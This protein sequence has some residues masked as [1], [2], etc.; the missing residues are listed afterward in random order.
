[1]DIL[2]RIL[3]DQ[4]GRARGQTIV[5]EN[6]PGGGSVIATEA[7]ARAAP[8]GSTVLMV[9]NSF[10]INPSLKATNYDPLTSFDPICH[11]ARTPNVFAV[12]ASSPYRTLA[13][14]LAAARGKP[15][16]LT[17]ASV[18]PATT[19]HI[20]IEMFKRAAKV[21]MT[22]VPFSG[23]APAVNAL[24]G[25]H[26]TALFA[27]HTA[28]GGHLEAGRIRGLAIASR[29]RI[30]SLP[31]LPTVTESGLGDYEVDAWFGLVAPAKVPREVASQLA[32]WFSAAMQAPE[33]KV[34]LAGQRLIPVGTCG[35]EFAAHLRNQYDQYSRVVREANIKAE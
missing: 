33:V 4:I 3:A 14:L 16:D 32:D 31:D 11:I 2:A 10:V 21:Q 29:T 19:Q 6:K 7:A 18:G 15:G 13:D 22:Y 9:S 20:G 34:K 25:S 1:M 8:D 12:N 27:T 30:E 5:V 26:V 17:L 24:L 23:D 28:V 35:R